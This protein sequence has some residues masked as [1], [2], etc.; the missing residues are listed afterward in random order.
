MKPVVVVVAREIVA[1]ESVAAPHLET[2]V[3]QVEA[4][5]RLSP[6]LVVPEPFA[7]EQAIG[8]EVVVVVDVEAGEEPHG[9][10]ELVGGASAKSP[11]REVLCLKRE[12][13]DGLV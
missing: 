8:E 7:P 2:H 11:R 13:V 1:V 10:E 6:L 5:A 4:R 12:R 9:P 3:P